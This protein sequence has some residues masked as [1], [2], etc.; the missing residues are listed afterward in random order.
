MGE[1]SSKTIDPADVP[2]P[3]QLRESSIEGHTCD[4]CSHYYFIAEA[5]C[6][7]CPWLN[8]RAT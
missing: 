2:M 3:Q 6:A 1:V 5:R 8:E 4:V 7:A